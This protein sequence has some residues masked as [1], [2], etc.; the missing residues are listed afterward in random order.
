MQRQ[1]A[2]FWLIFSDIFDAST[3]FFL[4]KLNHT[5]CQRKQIFEPCNISVADCLFR[6]SIAFEPEAHGV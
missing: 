2:S 3:I 4:S 1:G 6:E 5:P